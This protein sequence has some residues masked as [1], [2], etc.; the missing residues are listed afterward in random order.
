MLTFV[1]LYHVANVFV[2]IPGLK[3]AHAYFYFT[4]KLK[5]NNGYEFSYLEK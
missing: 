4:F 2:V 5:E 1:T 3:A